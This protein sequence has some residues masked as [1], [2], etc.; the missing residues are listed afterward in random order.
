MK[1][2]FS[3]FKT[4]DAAFELSVRCKRILNIPSNLQPDQRTVWSN[5]KAPFFQAVTD[6]LT[7]AT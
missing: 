2:S 1:I 4:P 7:V 5:T 3:S 6:V